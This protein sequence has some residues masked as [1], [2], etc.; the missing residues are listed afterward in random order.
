MAKDPGDCGW[1]NLAVFAGQVEYISFSSAY[2]CNGA[3]GLPG[4]LPGLPDTWAA[5]SLSSSGEEGYSG[6]DS[7]H[8]GPSGKAPMDPARLRINLD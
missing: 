5:L 6:M 7:Q 1:I 2:M 4:R 3:S 8:E